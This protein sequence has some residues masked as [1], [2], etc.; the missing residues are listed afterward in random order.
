MSETETDWKAQAL[1][2]ATRNKDL[3]EKLWQATG[4]LGYP[5]PGHIKETGEYKCGLCESKAKIIV[6]VEAQRYA[7]YQVIKILAETR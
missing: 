1:R 3:E 4:A 5:V 2:L 6:E 7:L